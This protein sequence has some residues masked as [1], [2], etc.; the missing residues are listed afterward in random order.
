[1]IQSNVTLVD[2][3]AEGIAAAQRLV[4]QNQNAFL[5]CTAG[6]VVLT[7]DGTEYTLHPGDVFL[8]PAFSKTEIRSCS[9]NLQGVY[10][11]ADFELVLNALEGMSGVE[12]ITQIR[13]HPVM[14]LSEQQNARLSH[15]IDL[16]RRRRLQDSPYCAGIVKALIQV[17]MYEIMDA[18]V[19]TSSAESNAQTRAD[20]VFLKFLSQLSHDFRREREV[21]Y[22]A[23]QLG[24][25]PR[26]FASII[27]DKS[28]ITPGAWIARYVIAEAKNLLSNPEMSIKQVAA[29]LNFPNQS[30]FGRYFR[31]NAGMT[32]GAYRKKQS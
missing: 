26:Y 9:D 18:Y 11:M 30:F 12:Y 10:G 3:D 28:G 23:S 25:T 6:N 29:A 13:Q 1:M 21:S 19:S 27:R 4:H 22:Y 15:M 2:V 32:P 8:Y 14:S 24:L 5:L 16:V 20:S 7:M 17:L 31:H